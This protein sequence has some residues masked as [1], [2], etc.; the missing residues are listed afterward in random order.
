MRLGRSSIGGPSTSL[1]LSDMES[2]EGEGSDQRHDTVC[3]K[4]V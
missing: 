1:T 2:K 4:H 3:S